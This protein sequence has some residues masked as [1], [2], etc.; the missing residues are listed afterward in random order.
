MIRMKPKVS[1]ILEIA[2]LQKGISLERSSQELKI[3]KKF[4]EALESGDFRIFSSGVHLT[5]FIKSY[6]KFLGLK[7]EEVL[8]FY[9]RDFDSDLLKPSYAKMRTGRFDFPRPERTLWLLV[10]LAVFIFF[11]YLLFKYY[12]YFRPPSLSIFNPSGDAVIKNTQILVQGRVCSQCFL[13]L[14]D[15][16][17]NVEADGSFTAN[18]NLK[19]GTNLL[20][21]VGINKAGKESRVLRNIIVEP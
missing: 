18:I 20:N 11:G 4:L 5:G 1:Q 17:I 3:Q 12:T 19:V 9:R 14:N 15:Q 21:F 13:K 7:E 6:A 2:R 16:E 10:G 8:A